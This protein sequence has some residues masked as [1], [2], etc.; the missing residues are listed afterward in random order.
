MGKEKNKGS[1]LQDCKITTLQLSKFSTVFSILAISYLF[2]FQF[3]QFQFCQF[4]IFA[5]YQLKIFQ[6]I[7][8]FNFGNFQ[9]R[10]LSILATFNFGSLQF[11][12]LSILTTFNFDHFQFWLFS[13][14]F[15]ES[16]PTATKYQL[17]G[18]CNQKLEIKMIKMNFKTLSL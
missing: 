4:S 5:I 17:Y 7:T 2:N 14:K 1:L 8:I 12:Q 6:F 3:W 13:C 15:L 10:Q 11:W 18:S 16:I 9:F